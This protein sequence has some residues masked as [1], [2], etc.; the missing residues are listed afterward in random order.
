M[1]SSFP[2]RWSFSY[3]KF[4]KYVTN[5]IAEPKYKY[6]QQEQVTVRNHN[7]STALERSYGTVMWS[8]YTQ[9]NINKVGKVQRRAVTWVSNDYSSYSSV[10]QMLNTLG[11]RSLEQRRADAGLILFYNICLWP[12]CIPIPAYIRHPVKMTSDYALHALHTNT[13]Y[14]NYYNYSFFPIVSVQWNK[15]PAQ[16]VMSLD[17]NSFR[18]I[19]CSLHHS[20]L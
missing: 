7:R 4:T 20:M 17:L 8:P 16:V 1:N 15:L 6:G 10:T 5:I 13:H 19:V 2:N 11:W 12:C 18:S 14:S 3:L 9:A